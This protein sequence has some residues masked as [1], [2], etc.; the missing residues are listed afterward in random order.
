MKYKRDEFVRE[1]ARSRGYTIKDAEIILDDIVETIISLL[2]N[3]HS[4]HLHGFMD[5]ETRT[6]KPR[7]MKQVQ[8]HDDIVI[9]EHT[10][11]KL[12]AGKRLKRAVAEYCALG[13]EE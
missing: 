1:F 13:G 8:T 7:A 6:L 2:R 10:T 12:I 3:G 4:V 11:V 5:I 9:P